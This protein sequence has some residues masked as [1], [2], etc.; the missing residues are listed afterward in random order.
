MRNLGTG[1]NA[2]P[3][4]VSQNC[5]CRPVHITSQLMRIEACAIAALDLPNKDQRRRAQAVEEGSAGLRTCR[6]IGVERIIGQ[7]G[8]RPPAF[9]YYRRRARLPEN[10]P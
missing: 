3:T 4:A 5:L 8:I 9:E 10:L 2:R 7:S 6:A 1:G